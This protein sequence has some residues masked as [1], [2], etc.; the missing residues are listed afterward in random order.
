[1]TIHKSNSAIDLHVHF[2]IK[3]KPI[4]EIEEFINSFVPNKK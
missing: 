4:S 1:M 2:T 3:S